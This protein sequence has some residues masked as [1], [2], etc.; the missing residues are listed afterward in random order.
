MRGKIS[1][2]APAALVGLVGAARAKKAVD[3]KVLDLREVTS[4]TDYF[5]LLTGANVRQVQAIADGVVEW[6]KSEGTRPTHVEGYSQGEWVL[7]DYSDFVVHVFSTVKREF[8]EL[9]RLWRDAVE[10]DIPEE[11]A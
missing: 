4:F 2:T 6:L 8:Y 1:V 9:E 3:V 10:V 11:A 5:V 7:L